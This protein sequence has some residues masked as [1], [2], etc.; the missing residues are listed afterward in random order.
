M[1]TK[2]IFPQTQN[3]TYLNTPA[4]GLISKK[5]KSQKVFDIQQLFDLG[6]DYM[7][8]EDCIV[9]QTKLKIAEVFHAETD[10][11]AITPN[12]SLA[13]NSI[14]EALPQSCT[15]LCLEEDYP[16]LSLAIQKR[17]FK[18]NSIPITAEI[19]SDI[20]R[21]IS[22]NTPNIF[23]VSKTQYLS[24]IHLETS[25]FKRL[26][27]DFPALIILVD[28]TQY[29]G[30]ENFNF[31]DSGIDLIISSCY[32]WLGAG[33]GVAI[34]MISGT[35]HQLLKPKQIGANSL[36]DKSK[37]LLK[38]MGF[39]EPGHYDFLAINALLAAL[40]LH[41]DEIGID[42]ISQQISKLS[43][44]VFEVLK[45]LHYL[46]D[47]VSQRKQHSSIFNLNINQDRFHDFKHHNII[48][49][50][51]GQ[52]LR[53]GFHYYNTIDDLNR[54]MNVLKTLKA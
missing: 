49:S 16:S 11:I 27:K 26:K 28:A 25:F 8:Q 4:F 42:K 34:V 50:R 31:K 3:T 51:R 20:Y 52:G 43:K 45:R 46:D 38:P 9:S 35:L 33:L 29:L 21:Y 5:V 37:V 30:V 14:L 6:S 13:F 15:F 47:M 2:S 48:L 18:Y 53:I 54:F 17:G 10:K 40:V 22:Q 12:F 23:A 41:Y 19:E 7:A 39:M 44:Q 32:K 36:K 1:N 24:G